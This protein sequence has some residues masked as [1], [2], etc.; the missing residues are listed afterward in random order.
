M[1]KLDLYIIKKFLG[2]FFYSI[3]LI[4]IIVI[5]FDVSEN[6]DDFLEKKA[7]VSEI[8]TRYYFNFIPYIVN[9]FSA[10]FTF[11]AVIF[12]TS[13]M[14]GNTE[15]VAILSSGVSFK[16]MLFPYMV[17]AIFIGI[18]SFFLTNFI[19][20]NAN[21]KRLAFEYQYMKHKSFGM[22]RNIHLQISPGTYVFVQ[23]FD[24]MNNTGY[25]FTMEKI[26]ETGMCYKLRADFLRYDTAKNSW[27]IENYNYRTINGMQESINYGY[28]IDTTLNLKPSDFSPKVKNVEIMNFGELRRFIEEE[29][30][31][32]SPNIN[33]YLIE[34]HKRIAYPFANIIL[35]LI[36][37][38]LSSRKVRGGI[39]LHLG[40]GLGISFSYIVF[41][42]FG[43]VFS[44]YGSI[45]PSI[46]AW[47]PNA[48]FAGIALFLLSKAPK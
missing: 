25:N 30:I 24:E 19:I 18:L 17:S 6:V 41:I 3:A 27:S 38:S 15:I 44:T 13:K 4:S 48:L 12:F 2:T 23:S 37:V 14:A 11:I 46:G 16:R 45:S 21:K 10:L 28:K 20:P 26:D 5:I 1:L 47:I 43:Q 29:K 42:Q 8:I 39:G 34:K 22:Q 35:T 31:K 33:F 40:L 32:G 7:P 36:G 9:L